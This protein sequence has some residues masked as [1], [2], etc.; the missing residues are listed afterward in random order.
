[1]RVRAILSRPEAELDYAEAKIALDRLVDPMADREALRPELDRLT[2]SA[3]RLAGPDAPAGVRLGA[4]RKLIYESGP[5]NGHRPFA[6]DHSDPDGTHVPNKL[7]HV[8]LERRLGNCVSMP[9]LFLI[10]A[11]RLG[12]D[13]A[14]ARAPLHILLRH[15]LPDG[16]I[17]NIE[18]TSGGHFTRDEWYC[19]NFPM[20][21]R[22]L[23]SGLYM[24]SLSRREAVTLMASTVLEQLAREERFEEAIAVADAI[25]EQDARAGEALVH[26]SSAYGRLLDREFTR[27]FP[28]PYLIPERLRSRRLMLIER[29]TS[30]LAAAEALGWSDQGATRLL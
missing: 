17:V 22:A 23:A 7:L 4:V 24:R 3:R 25:L 13:I 26:Q 19:Q 6:Y 14:L 28:I 21:E 30:L 15:R 12:V 27:A 29:N 8:Y 2:E 16:R 18:A 20:S 10:L 5:W 1:V 9:I 11:D